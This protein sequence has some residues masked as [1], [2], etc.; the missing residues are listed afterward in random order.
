M[1]SLWFLVPLGCALFS[2]NAHAACT[3]ASPTWSATPDYASVSTCIGNAAPGDTVN[4]LAGSAIWNSTL[5]IT[6]GIN[7]IGAGIGL[8]TITNAT[9]GGLGYTGKHCWAYNPTDYTLNAPFRISGFSIDLGGTAGWLYLGK[10]GKRAPFTV[11]TKVRVDHNRVFNPSNSVTASMIW[12]TGTTYGV[13]D[14]NSF[15]GAFYAFKSDPQIVD[16]YG[17]YTTSP[18]KDFEFGSDKYMYWE[19]NTISLSTN[20]NLLIESQYGGRYVFRYNTITGAASYSLFEMHGYQPDMPSVFGGE[21]YGNRVSSGGTLHKTRGGKSMVFFNSIVGGATNVAYTSL[22]VCPTQAPDMQMVHDTYWFRSRAD[23][24]GALTGTN[25]SG[26]IT[27]AGRSGIVMLGRDVISDSSSPGVG[28][29][30]LANL[31]A[32]CTPGQGYW[33]TNQSCSDLTGMVGASPATPIAGTL[34][35]C[36]SANTWAPYYEPFTYPHPL[37]AGEKANLSVPLNLRVP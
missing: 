11:Q 15:E 35:K 2:A 23:Y 28:C 27:C 26:N 5:T 14:H 20:D 7:L 36:M 17:W 34:Y 21:I 18:Q 29:G 30:P 19:D 31:P 3:G 16:A 13:V 37:T 25:V 4:V 10:D 6:K 1:K 33:A 22:V 9:A 24:A 8:T 32:T 12:T